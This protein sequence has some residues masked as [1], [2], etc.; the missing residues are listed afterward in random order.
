MN[1]LVFFT[2]FIVVTIIVIWFVE[3]LT[4][5]LSKKIFKKHLQAIN[6]KEKQI[7]EYQNLTILAMI[8]KEKEAV[9]GFQDMA[10]ELYWQ[11]FF[12]KLMMFSSLFFLLL[13]P[14]MLLAHYLLRRKFSSSFA[15]I[16]VVAIL[17]FMAKTVYGYVVNLVLMRKE[18]TKNNMDRKI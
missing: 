12:Q 4:Y 6:E 9:H 17:Y 11:I 8:S 7:Q 1:N 3:K 13:S 15:F 10:N 5:R 14:Y 2:I 16:F 18:A